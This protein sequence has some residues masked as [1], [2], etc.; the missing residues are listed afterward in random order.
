MDA[1]RPGVVPAFTKIFDTSPATEGHFIS[2]RET[3][4]NMASSISTLPSR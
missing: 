4:T 3:L 1:H 2:S